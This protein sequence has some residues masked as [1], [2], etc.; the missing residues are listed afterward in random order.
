MP[1]CGYNVRAVVA[2]FN[3]EWGVA[4]NYKYL[5]PHCLR[6]AGVLLLLASA[7]RAEQVE[8]L[9]D[10]WGIPHV[11]AGTDAGAFYGLGYATAADRAFQMTYS[12]RIIQGRLSE[13][14]GEIRSVSGKESSLDHD[15]KMRTFGFHRGRSGWRQR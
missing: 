2:D 9:R 5:H 3:F 1:M 13:V 6:M 15:K 14:V 4:V 8:I 7:T 10:P 12:L 11:I